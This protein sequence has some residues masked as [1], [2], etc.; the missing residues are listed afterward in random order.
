MLAV[1]SFQ[2]QIYQVSI[3]TGDVSAIPLAKPYKGVAIDLNEF[4]SQIYWS[5]NQVPAIMTSYIDGLDERVFFKLPN[6]KLQGCFMKF[7]GMLYTE[8]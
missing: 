8:I 1:D 3:D 4:T 7:I 6:G 5:D 2:K